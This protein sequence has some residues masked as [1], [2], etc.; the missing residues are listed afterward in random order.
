MRKIHLVQFLFL[1]QL[2]RGHSANIEVTFIFHFE[3]DEILRAILI[4][5]FLIWT[6]RARHVLLHLIVYWAYYV[7]QFRGKHVT[8][9]YT[10]LLFG[11]F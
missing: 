7:N 10:N 2:A 1:W 8:R 4:I 9:F 3:F 11:H 6:L 5:R